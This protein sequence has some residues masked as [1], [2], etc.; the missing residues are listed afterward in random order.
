MPKI[1]VK[2]TLVTPDTILEKKYKAIY[3][4]NENKIVYK[5]ENNTMVQLELNDLKLRRENDELWMEYPF[6]KEKIT[7]GKIMM[8]SLKKELNLSINTKNIIKEA[9]NIKIDYQLDSEEYKYQ[10]EV[11]E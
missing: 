6:T 10:L 1:N 7:T 4:P 11:I 9:K 3:H 5:E 8:K 2:V